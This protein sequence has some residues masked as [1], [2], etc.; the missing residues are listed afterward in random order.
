MASCPSTS[1]R[2][3]RIGFDADDSVQNYIRRSSSEVRKHREKELRRSISQQRDLL[4][5]EALREVVFETSSPL[6]LPYRLA[7]LAR[8]PKLRRIEL[9]TPDDCIVE[10]LPGILQE[11]C[12]DL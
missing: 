8:C 12:L 9:D 7:F 10:Y 4:P 11:F 6:I 2:R 3:L 1:L 5:F